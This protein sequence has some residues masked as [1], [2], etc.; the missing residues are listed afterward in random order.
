MNA[1]VVF[2]SSCFAP[3]GLMV[4]SEVS[5]EF[6]SDIWFIYQFNCRIQQI[7]MCTDF[8]R[9]LQNLSF[10]KTHLVGANI[11]MLVFEQSVLKS[12]GNKNSLK[13]VFL[14]LKGK[15]GDKFPYILFPIYIYIYIYISHL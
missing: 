11:L 3:F 15:L 5:V 12:A 10:I 1:E 6:S 14:L 2:R 8:F 13:H 7:F 4:I 9:L